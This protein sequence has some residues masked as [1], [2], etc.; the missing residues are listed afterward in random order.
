M[1]QLPQR[2]AQQLTFEHTCEHTTCGGQVQHQVGLRHG[3]GVKVHV[4]RRTALNQL[5]TNWWWGGSSSAEASAGDRRW[6]QWIS[7]RCL[8]GKA[9]C[10]QNEG[11]A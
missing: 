9:G 5:A 6:L 3:E 2:I 1:E 10:D 8:L 11:G 7:E 4:P